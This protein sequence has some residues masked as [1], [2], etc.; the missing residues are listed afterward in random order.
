MFRSNPVRLCAPLLLLFVTACGGGGGGGSSSGGDLS[1]RSLQGG[2]TTSDNRTTLAFENPSPNLSEEDTQLHFTG[3]SNFGAQFVTPPAAFNAGLGPTFNNNSCDACHTKNGRGQPVFGTGPLGSQALLRISIPGGAPEVPG[4][5]GIVPGLGTQL[6]DHA[7]FG[8]SAEGTVQLS[9][10]T[11]EGSYADGTPYQ[12]RRPKISVRLA[13]GSNLPPSVMTSMRVPPPI[14]GLGLLEAVPDSEILSRQDP[15]DADGNGISGRANVVYNA[16]TGQT[17]I[18]RFGRKANRPTLIQQ[19]A[20]AY[21]N[22]MGVTNP[23]FNNGEPE[24]EVSIDV[25]KSVEFYTQTLAVPRAG[26]VND[27]VVMQ[28]EAL[29]K[30]FGCIGCHVAPLQ[31]GPHPVES[32]SNQ[33]IFPYTDLLLHDMGAGLADNRP[34][35]LADGN[36]WR[37]PALWGVGVTSTILSA[38]ATF[39]HD[40]RAR[41]LE[42]AI[43]WHGGEAQGAK[44]KFRTAPADNRAALIAFLRS[45]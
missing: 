28:G 3:D 5:V 20:S 36:E 15:D 22:D 31:T 41:T 18:G 37:T 17:S 8:N 38:T 4:G 12:L 42:E 40:G 27:P 16:E 30:Q 45:L 7:T 23:I 9:F 43:L 21:F 44:E 26:N 10:E 2:D 32:V 35:F 14:F 1:D 34:D 39:L 25:L 11:E 29:F 6:Q 33:T 13:D 19:A 24:T